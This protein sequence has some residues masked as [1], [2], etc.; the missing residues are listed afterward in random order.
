MEG[1][2]GTADLSRHSR[3]GVFRKRAK[4]PLL[5]SHAANGGDA[6]IC[7]LRPLNLRECSGQ[8]IPIYTYAM[9]NMRKSLG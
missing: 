9:A 2:G 4:S 6:V 3:V 8:Y 7:P 1:E 5:L